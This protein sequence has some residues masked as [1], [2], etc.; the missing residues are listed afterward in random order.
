MKRTKTGTVEVDD[1]LDYVVEKEKH[2]GRVLGAIIGFTSALVLVGLSLG[3]KAAS[4]DPAIQFG[5]QG[6]YWYENWKKQGVYGDPLNIW[7]TY[8]SGLERGREVYDPEADAWYWLDACYDGK[9]AQNKEVWMPY[10]FQGEDPG[11]TK[12]KWVRY[13]DNGKMIK[14]WY[15]VIDPDDASGETVSRAWYYNPITGEMCKETAGS[16][17]YIPYYGALVECEFDPFTGELY[18]PEWSSYEGWDIHGFTEWYETT[19]LYPD[20]TFVHLSPQGE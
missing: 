3:A 8:H 5:R 12:G 7:D 16:G 2:R 11:S 17:I 9:I 4:E 15:C 18:R 19:V 1:I 10:I 20:G 13:D 14:G 6:D